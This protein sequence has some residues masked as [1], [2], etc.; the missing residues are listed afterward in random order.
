MKV[1]IS[2]NITTILVD[3]FDTLVGR[4]CHPEVVKRKWSA[5]IIN[6]YRINLTVDCLY[7]LRLRIEAGLCAMSEMHGDDAEFRYKEMSTALYYELK[8]SGIICRIPDLASFVSHCYDLEMAIELSVQKP[9]LSTIELLRSEKRKN[10]Q[11]YLLSDFY[12][13]VNSIKKFIIHHGIDEIFDDVFVSSEYKRTKREG[14]AFDWVIN[15]LK[16][17]TKNTI[18]LGDNAHSDVA[19][20]KSR[21][22]MAY[23]LSVDQSDYMSNLAQDLQRKLIQK[24]IVDITKNYKYNFNW[25]SSAI[26][27]F[28]HR[29]YW[30]L[31]TNRALNVYFFSREG[32]F[33]QK[34]FEKYQSSLPSTFWKV[35]THYM[36]VSRR[37]TYLPSLGTLNKKTFNK[38]LYQYQT[39]SIS[40]FLKSINLDKYESFL[41]QVLIEYDFNVPY[42]N[43]GESAAF[44]SLIEN[45]DFKKIYDIERN[46][47]N[48]YLNSYCN[49]LMD[50]RNEEFVYV[51][52]VGWKGSIQDNISKAT[53]RKFFGYYFGI[54][55]GAECSNVNIKDGLL[56]DHQWGQRAGN[57]VFN[58]FRAGFEVLMGASHGSLK[59]YNDSIKNFIFDNN[60]TEMRIYNERIAPFQHK[61]LIQFDE[62]NKIINTYS[63]SD[64]EISEAVRNDYF[65][66]VMLPSRDERDEFSSIQ[67]YENFGVFDYS[68]FG[69]NKKS[70]FKYYKNLFKNPR[71]T[72]GSS[73]WKP[74]DFHANGVGY[75]K[76]IYCSVK[77]LKFKSH[78]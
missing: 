63:V 39:C 5:F 24:K 71:F 48:S 1:T 23:H 72:I 46:E 75:L 60:E 59:C 34:A 68:S 36:Y 35:K 16:L 2:D 50:K 3:F 49:S 61:A 51:V 69:I 13:D 4:T 53:G 56:F 12:L 40:A 22:L 62:F 27:L 57:D 7:E 45:S 32:E 19:M 15:K 37:A 70:S 65:N 33:L 42:P 76:Y 10:K 73:W 47:Q 44:L 29:L 77:F 11:I 67:H 43:F 8:R 14:R 74:L 54:H 18:M 6:S 26:Y 21:G 41:K 66:G 30:A 17:N 28:T 31:A 55:E 64:N 25:V 38:L 58:E 52:D 9:I 78:K 20:P